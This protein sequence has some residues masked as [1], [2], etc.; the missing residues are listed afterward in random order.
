MTD[1][2]KKILVALDGSKNSMRGLNS[3]IS[4]AKPMGAEI[5]GVYVRPT[6]PI[7]GRMKPMY[8]EKLT[9]DEAFLGL[10]KKNAVKNGVKF[11][12]KITEFQ[13]P[14]KYIVK[15]AQDQ[16]FDLIVVGAR[17]MSSAKEIF[18]GSVSNYI[19]HKSKIQVLVVK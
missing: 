3:A 2:I 19:V 8:S 6:P 9:K 13:N 15:L 14:G 12:A 7:F 18:L 5:K 1:K 4:L 11:S 16:N 17:G 10:A